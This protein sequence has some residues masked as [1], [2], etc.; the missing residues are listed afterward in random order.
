VLFSGDFF[1]APPRILFDLEA[2]LRGKEVALAEMVIADFFAAADTGTIS[3]AP[4]DFSDAL[5]DAVANR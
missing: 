5:N 1:V 2:A 3:L 4:T